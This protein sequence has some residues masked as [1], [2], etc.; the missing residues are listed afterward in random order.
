MNRKAFRSTILLVLCLVATPLS[1]GQ[2]YGQESTPLKGALT[3]PD[4]EHLQ[5]LTT[6]DGSS[7]VGR[8]TE[9]GETEIQF[10]TELG[11]ITIPISKIKEIK[12]IPVTSMKKGTYWFPNPNATRL[13][14][15]PTA[16]M[17]REGEGYF[18]DYYLF[19]PGFAYGISD[20]ITIG[21]GMS[22][23]PFV[24]IDDQIFYITPK[25]GLKAGPRTN[26]AAGALLIKIPGFSDDGESPLVGILYG[27]GTFGTSDGNL[28]AG[29]GY[30]FVDGDFADKPM[31]MIG[32]EQRFARR[33]SFVTENYIFPGIDQPFISYGIRFFGEK[34]SVDLALLN[35]IGEGI[36]FPGF[37]YVD[38]VFK[39]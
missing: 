32:G 26:F 22:L 36:F 20:N 12:G 14:F 24:G 17:L 6:R 10:E 8:I 9:I 38:F 5:I 15:A 1:I 30:G 7:F 3:I 29:L 39:F 25:V 27:V 18:A 28:T 34:L 13:Y 2:V 37:P 31:V 11:K 23:I 33:A 21:G 4:S 35:T 16:R 19:F